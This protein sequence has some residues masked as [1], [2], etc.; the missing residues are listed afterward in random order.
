MAVL[1]YIAFFIFSIC[2]YRF[3]VGDDV[4]H[5]FT[6]SYNFYE[7]K[8]NSGIGVQVT[9]FQTL[10]ESLRMKYLYHSGRMVGYTL[11]PLLSI[12]GQF[13]VAL[14]TVMI[15]V[16][17][18]LLAVK[19][20]YFEDNPLLHP[21]P[22]FLCFAVFFYFNPP[23]GYLLLWTM[24]SIYVTAILLLLAYIT[25]LR[26]M[27]AKEESFTFTKFAVV[28]VLG[29]LA[30]LTQEVFALVF[31]LVAT[32][33]TTLTF[34][35]KRDY[36]VFLYLLG[37][38][39]GFLL[40]LTAP[41]NFARLAL[42]HDAIPF[43]VPIL[44]R[45]KQS[46]IDH[47]RATVEYVIPA[48]FFLIGLFYYV[49]QALRRL[50]LRTMPEF[51]DVLF[52][53]AICIILV[54]GVFPQA[55]MYGVLGFLCLMS[56]AILTAFR[57]TNL[58]TWFERQSWSGYFSAAGITIA[59][60]TLL[61]VDLPWLKQLQSDSQTWREKIHKAVT[62]HQP[63]VYVQ[64]FSTLPNA[65][66]SLTKNNYNRFTLNDLTNDGAEYTR[67]YYRKLFKVHIKPR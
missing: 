48:L 54:W 5:Q 3:P 60:V 26:K 49:P 15:V 41:G 11:L 10:V 6:T 64:K 7:P 37:L 67:E 45:M 58:T 42:S 52:F 55:P 36:K 21:I 39:V 47:G 23:I 29:L 53:A 22:I 30:G 1:G 24:V 57:H 56:I 38:G 61:I 35:K 65:R 33:T 31:L 9:N 2:Y 63:E 19:N 51:E 18:L 25:L 17:V 13:T 66:L 4:L 40:S 28:N 20:I 14:L 62:E 34:Y 16:G 12:F 50:R 46:I 27:L 32:L 8:Q 44:V 43:A 59:L